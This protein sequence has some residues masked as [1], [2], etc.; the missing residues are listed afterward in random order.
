MDGKALEAALALWRMPSMRTALRQRPL[1][2]GVGEL[3]DLAAGS[4]DRV[5]QAAARA[6]VP[7]GQ[8][9]EA[10]RFYITEILMFEGADAYRVLGVS[11]GAEASQVKAHHRAL[12]RW[13]HP[14]RRHDDWESVYAKRVNIAWGELRSPER[15]EAYD[16]RN[17][18]MPAHVEE[19]LAPR[20]VLVTDWRAAPGEEVQWRRW[21]ASGVV[22]VAC[23]WLVVLAARQANAPP[24]E[25]IAASDPPAD[26]QRAAAPPDLAALVDRAAARARQPKAA[27]VIATPQQPK[28]SAPSPAPQAKKVLPPAM[29]AK[30]DVRAAVTVSQKQL[31]PPVKVAVVALPAA[32]QAKDAPP[33]R[34][35]PRAATIKRAVVVVVPRP[36]QQPATTRTID[37]PPAQVVSVVADM[38]QL[39]RVRLAHRRGDEVTRYLVSSSSGIPPIWRSVAAQDAAAS[40][41]QRLMAGRPRV[42][43]LLKPARFGEP[44]WRI[45][46]DRA[47]MAATIERSGSEAGEGSLQ[48][49]LAW[50]DGMWLVDTI[51][52]E[53]LP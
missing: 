10:V 46:S 53:N 38:A 8:V 49:G 50:R 20:R 34:T 18:G 35:P 36:T 29:P 9:L 51:N 12:L 14:D 4:H 26:P 25:W 37:S 39:E 16:A 1:P 45:A 47:T 41:R 31:P 52:A 2:E 48:V 22:V 40:I 5:A 17:A 32:D 33:L 24:P 23:L 44:T 13:L 15:C 11:R 43:R 19:G 42:A 21:L 7:P 27:V 28:H 3:I 30:A 6:D